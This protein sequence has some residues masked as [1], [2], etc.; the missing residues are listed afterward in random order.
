MTE[1]AAHVRHLF[2]QVTTT[3]TLDLA[4]WCEFKAEH[5]VQ[6]QQCE[7][8]LVE[9]LQHVLVLANEQ[10]REMERLAVALARRG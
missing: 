10:Q 7:P 2:D 1:T 8:T 9:T 4:T 6:G 3:G 5:G